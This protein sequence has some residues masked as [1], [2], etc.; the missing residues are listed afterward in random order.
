MLFPVKQFTS[1]SKLL[2]ETE[3][4]TVVAEDC[5]FSSYESVILHKTDLLTA[6]LHSWLACVLICA[7]E[8]LV[9]RKNSDRMLVVAEQ[10]ISNGLVSQQNKKGQDMLPLNMLPFYVEGWHLSPYSGLVG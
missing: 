8:N 9:A 7:R 6:T 10:Y 4:A 2:G 3:K 5:L 1:L